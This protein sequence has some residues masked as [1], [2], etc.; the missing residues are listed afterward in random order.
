MTSILA[1]FLSL[2]L[3][4]ASTDGGAMLAGK[5]LDPRVAECGL[6]IS[7]TEL[8][9]I[10]PFIRT[11]GGLS[12]AVRLEIASRSPAG[13]SVIRQSGRFEKDEVALRSTL[14]FPSKIKVALVFSDA[15]GA[16][17][18]RLDTEHD[19]DAAPRNI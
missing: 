17:V 4:E 5:P 2:L 18:C 1:A 7:G 14:S 8:V 11:L 15:T 3:G 9:E 6:R 13:T 10:A 12:G 19:L 16:E